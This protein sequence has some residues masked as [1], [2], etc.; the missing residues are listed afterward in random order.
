[1]NKNITTIVLDMSRSLTI[2]PSQRGSDVFKDN[3]EQ[4]KHTGLVILF[5]V[6]TLS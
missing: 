6:S 4:C 3:F 5:L 2:K 1:M